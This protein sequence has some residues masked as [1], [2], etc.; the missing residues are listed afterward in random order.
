MSDGTSTRPLMS[1]GSWRTLSDRYSDS[2]NGPSIWDRGGTGGDGGSGGRSCEVCQHR[3]AQSSRRKVPARCVFCAHHEF[4]PPLETVGERP[5]RLLGR[6]DH[7]G[8]ATESWAGGAASS[9]ATLGTGRVTSVGEE[10]EVD[11]RKRR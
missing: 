10:G 11:E 2:W 3:C 6:D 8:T 7:G 4:G 5:P 9:D 1:C